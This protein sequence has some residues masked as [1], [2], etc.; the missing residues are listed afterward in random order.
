MFSIT[1]RIGVLSWW[2]MMIAFS[3]M[4][5]ATGCGV[6]TMTAPVRWNALAERQLHVAVPGGRSTIR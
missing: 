1:P 6:V 4:F 5:T 3:A 2:N